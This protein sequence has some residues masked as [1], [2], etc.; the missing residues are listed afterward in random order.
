VATARPVLESALKSPEAVCEV[1]EG[2]LEGLRVT[3]F[4]CGCSKLQELRRA[5]LAKIPGWAESRLGSR[6]EKG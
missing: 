1:L 6:V 2:V 4:G 5:P 3:M